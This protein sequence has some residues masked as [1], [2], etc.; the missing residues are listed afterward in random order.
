LAF[1]PEFKWFCIAARE[2]RTLSK[3]IVSKG[4]YES[5]CVILN[6]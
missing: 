4:D 2:L 6:V 1:L 3:F 5:V